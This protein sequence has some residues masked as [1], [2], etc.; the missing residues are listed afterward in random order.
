[1][2]NIIKRF[3]EAWKRSQQRELQAKAIDRV[4]L[5][6]FNGKIVLAIDGIM[7]QGMEAKDAQGWVT[8]LEETRKLY[9]ETRT[10]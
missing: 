7:V 3:A 10:R 8:V 2:K 6:F 5:E 9:V 4:R 1:M